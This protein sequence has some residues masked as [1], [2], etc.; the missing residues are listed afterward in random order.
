[1]LLW[2]AATNGYLCQQS[3]LPLIP[4]PP[5]I[6]NPGD[7]SLRDRSVAGRSSARRGARSARRKVAPA[8]TN[9]N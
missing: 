9:L 4:P 7:R 3:Y 1:M 5:A 2:L 8:R 6:L